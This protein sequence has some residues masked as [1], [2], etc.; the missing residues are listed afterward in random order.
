MWDRGIAN[1]FSRRVAT[2]TRLQ[3]E[4][5]E[6]GAASLGI[7]LQHFGRYVPLIQ[8]RELC[9]VS[10]DGSDAANLVLAARSL[11]LT[12]KGFKRDFPLWPS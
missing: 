7:I 10:R 5:T 12:A 4:N 3:M 1:L 2:P 11:G 6:C 9:G 8:L